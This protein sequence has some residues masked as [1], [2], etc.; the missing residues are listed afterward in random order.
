[1]KSPEKVFFTKRTQPSQ[2]KHEPNPVSSTPCWPGFPPQT[3]G[4]S[5]PFPRLC[6]TRTQRVG[7][8]ESGV[9]QTAIGRCK[10]SGGTSAPPKGE[11]LRDLLIGVTN[12]FREAE[13][14]EAIQKQVIPQVFEGKTAESVIRIWV[15][16]CST[17]EE[18]Y[19]LAILLQEWMEEKKKNFKVQIFATDIDRE[20]IDR[21]RAGV[22]PASIIAD[23]SPERLAQYFRPED[24]DGNSYRIHKTIRDM[25]SFSEHDLIKDPPFSRL[26][27]ISCRNLLIYMGTELQKKAHA[28]IPLCSESGRDPGFGVFGKRWRL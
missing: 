18:A 2:T 12:F 6:G 22:Y 23:V 28:A 10:T 26:D 5:V 9:P 7:G 8:T 27:L 3:P 4:F 19:S 24:A 11:S 21:A 15:P 17:G 14:F 25:L 16:G 1:M 20:A 13:I